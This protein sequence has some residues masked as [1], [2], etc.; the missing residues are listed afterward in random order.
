MSASRILSV[1]FASA[2]VAIGGCAGAPK[3]PPALPEPAAQSRVSHFAGSPLSGPMS[4]AVPA[5]A[6]QDALA[7]RV[8]LV[9]LENVPAVGKPLG[10]EA[11]LILATR[12]GSPVLPSSRVTAAARFEALPSADQFQT[13][14][15]AV[16]AGRKRPFF[17]A[18][19]AVP[20]GVSAM[21]EVVSTRLFDS[22]VASIESA[23][24]LQLY[25][26]QPAAKVAAD[27]PQPVQVAVAIEDLASSDDDLSPG[28]QTVQRELAVVDRQF[29]GERQYLAVVV[30]MALGG[31]AN[32]A[33]RGVAALIEIAPGDSSPEHEQTVASA[34]DQVR[35]SAEFAASRP[36]TLP[37]SRGEL[38]ALRAASESLSNTS[39]LRPTIVYLAGQTGARLC[40]DFALVADD[41]V[42]K[43]LGEGCKAMIDGAI[44]AGMTDA[45]SASVGFLL[46]KAAFQ[47]A[48]RLLNDGKLPT[49]LASVLSNYAGEAGRNPASIE[50]VARNLNSRKDFS[51]RL[52]AEN[53]IYL[54]DVSPAARVRA[55]DWLAARGHA[56]AG[57]DPLGPLKERRLAIEKGLPAVPSR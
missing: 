6:P 3:E 50:E 29:V 34:M 15:L 8:E 17:N 39:R 28:A 44:T 9:A 49:E 32:G 43:R 38:A 1:F 21:V 57:Y 40:E 26:Y 45:E 10:A 4:K 16:A 5:P 23:A 13:G 30:P 52:L 35:Q 33:V 2:F 55:Y 11:R 47:A 24:R 19:A 56:P 20:R 31:D 41:S 18:R 7:V 37:V 42:L 53:L 54:E 36:T 51:E 48:G 46:D 25:V 27:Q 14:V 22:R 12:L